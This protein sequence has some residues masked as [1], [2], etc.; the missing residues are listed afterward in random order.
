MKKNVFTY[1]GFS[2]SIGV[3]VEDNCLYGK[4]LFINDLVNYRAETPADLE[5]E[6]KAAVDD[7]LE[8]CQELQLEPNKPFSGTF[9]V[10]LDP[11]LHK[12]IALAAYQ[13][14][15]SINQYIKDTLSGHIKQMNVN[16]VHHKHTHIYSYEIEA[17]I[18]TLESESCQKPKLRVVH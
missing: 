4:I 18:P 6:F 9:N 11:E 13:E 12:K 3:S 7:Y 14:D 16:T 2:G 5:N 1:K 15:V 8:T 17:P 10:R